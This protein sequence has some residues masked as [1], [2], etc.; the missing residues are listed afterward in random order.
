[1][2]EALE[3]YNNSVEKIDIIKFTMPYLIHIKWSFYKRF[4]IT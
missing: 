4:L 3:K 2:I 1:M